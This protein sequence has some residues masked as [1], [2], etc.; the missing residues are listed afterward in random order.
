[1][2]RNNG[3][4]RKKSG[5][6]E[7]KEK[8][9]MRID[10][11]NWKKRNDKMKDNTTQGVRIYQAAHLPVSKPTLPPPRCPYVPHLPPYISPLLSQA[12]GWGQLFPHL[13]PSVV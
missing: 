5:N 9:G 6:N 12:G 11:R 8:E 3:K 2:V 13:Q 1:M 10:K 4:Y 7:E